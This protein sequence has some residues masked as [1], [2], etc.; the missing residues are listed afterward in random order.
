MNGE[1]ALVGNPNCGKT[2]LFN[3]LTGSSQIVGNWPG[4]T[5]ERKSGSIQL[6][7]LEL[8]LVD[9]PGL[10]SLSE[11]GGADE[12]VARNYLTQTPPAL[13]LN[14]LDARQLERQL[15]L[16][17]QLIEQGL[18]MVV[19]LGMSDLARRSGIQVDAAALA[20][21]LGVPVL[22]VVAHRTEGV[23]NL[24]TA[25]Q[26]AWPSAPAPQHYAPIVE[27]A[28]AKL[29][30]SGLSRFAA[31]SA[32]EGCEVQDPALLPILDA[33]RN[34]LA[35]AYGDDADIAVADGRY[36]RIAAIT[37]AVVSRPTQPL[38]QH[39]LDRWVLNRWM[40]LPIFLLVMYL[41]FSW[42]VNVG[43]A[44]VDGFDGVTAAVFVTGSE[45]LLT[46]LQAPAW[47]ILLLADGAGEGLRTVAAFIPTLG[48]L[49]LALGLLE[50][51]GY[52]ARAAFVI[53]RLM[54]TLGLPG[55]AF[56][57]MMVGFGCNVP[58]ILATRTLEGRPARILA[59]MMIPF[60][61]CG[62]RLPVYVLLATAFF[63]QQGGQVVMSLYL[64]GLAAALA[65]GLL[66]RPLL[67]RT[68]MPSALLE[69]PSWHQPNLRNVLRQAWHRLSGFMLGAGRLIVPMVIVINLLSA[70]D[71]K[72]QLRPEA[73][74]ASL[75]AAAARSL[76]PA[77]APIGI[78][79]D[80]WPA[81]VGLITGVLAK[82]AVAG[83]LIAS[84]SRLAG[85]TGNDAAPLSVGEQIKLAAAT[86]PAKLQAL[87]QNLT[88]PLGLNGLEADAAAQVHQLAPAITALR[89]HFGS[90][91]T[92]YAYLLF[93]L[94]YTP[95]VAALA[96]LRSEVGSRWMLVSA[97]WTLLL[98]YSTAS[99]YRKASDQLGTV[100]L[101]SA[102]LLLV[103]LAA[104][105]LLL[106]RRAATATATTLAA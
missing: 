61:S 72:L 33:A 36:T 46:T 80:N 20:N 51:C 104:A 19:L 47:L 40:G 77:L 68:D 6:N 78:Q 38:V 42:S 70:V 3:Q 32:L 43:G 24:L 10:Y 90:V 63:P 73:P 85:D 29:S 16:T 79:P 106:Q 101:T 35:I 97:G 60:V 52:L 94:L 69:L 98:A 18:P 87:T 83:T 21:E 23:A 26:Q 95:C 59:S 11:G 37:E 8:R 64:A 54:R 58:A 93:V 96:A 9:L 57:P 50:D 30:S 25:L 5:V 103:I 12:A 62:A 4:V 91:E 27:T 2:S 99:L 1:I 84:Y 45:Q 76:T 81:T 53:D 74:D 56:V 75:L 65:T 86:I 71:T 22:E 39:G 41:M 44:F 82:E 102:G 48:C 88:D 17:L 105:G 15:Y 14:L 89:L 100:P 92:A 66:L 7:K 31:L 55:R 49:Y 67:L 28:I 13:V 34:E